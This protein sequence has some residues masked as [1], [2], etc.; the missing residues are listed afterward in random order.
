MNVAREQNKICDKYLEDDS[1]YLFMKQI[2]EIVGLHY[3]K[4]LSK[5]KQLRKIPVSYLS[6]EAWGRGRK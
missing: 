3:M 2:N 4:N 6:K 1:I 5:W